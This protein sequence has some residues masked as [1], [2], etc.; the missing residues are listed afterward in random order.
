MLWMIDRD[1]HYVPCQSSESGM[2]IC[3]G[4]GQVPVNR[5]VNAQPER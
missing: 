1:R 5:H 3:P 4:F 2:W